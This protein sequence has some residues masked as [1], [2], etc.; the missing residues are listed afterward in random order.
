MWEPQMILADQGWRV[1]A[2][3][4]RGFDGGSGDPPA[5]TVDDYAADVIDLLDGLHVE[6]AVVCGLSMGGYAAFALLRLAPRY[7]RGLVLADTRSQADTPEGVEGMLKLLDDKGPAAIAD[8]MVPKLLGAST[9]ERQPELADRVRK[10]VLSNPAAA[11][12]GGIR[13]LMS[14]PDSTKLLQTIHC[15]TLVVVGEEDVLTPPA[16]S[17]EMHRAIAGSELTK[18]PGAGH[19][20]NLESPAAF[21]AA[22]G[23]FLTHRV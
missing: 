16:F 14:R 10:L 6:D 12:A 7:V 15:P 4:F 1:V 21:N 17:E 18:I 2:P 8:E 5:S 3:Q 23:G 13:V 19:L 22:L 9:R 20:S 11:I